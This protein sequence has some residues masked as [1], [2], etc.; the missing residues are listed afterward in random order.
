M[1]DGLAIPITIGLATGIVFVFVMSFPTTF[2]NPPVLYA[3]T[4]NPLG[5]DARVAFVR[6]YTHSC[7]KSPCPDAELFMLKTI[8]TKPAWLFGYRVCNESIPFAC[9]QEEGFSSASAN[10]SSE[11]RARPPAFW[12]GA[13]MGD[14]N[15][16]VGS[17]VHIWVKISPNVITIENNS[18]V[19]HVDEKNIGWVDLGESKIIEYNYREMRAE[20]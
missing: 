1:S 10:P 3:T 18:E 20:R 2:Q 19:F 8:H 16:K 9:V 12:G 4:D 11:E 7:I 17:T 14:L 6:N 15:W 5:F 13:T